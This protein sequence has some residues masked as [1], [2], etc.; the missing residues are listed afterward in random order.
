MKLGFVITNDKASYF[1]KEDSLSLFSVAKKAAMNKQWMKPSAPFGDLIFY[2][3]IISR[4]GQSQALLYKHHCNWLS[5]VILLF[6]SI[7]YFGTKPRW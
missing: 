7:V 4:H 1:A 2:S 3:Y 6:L 5:E